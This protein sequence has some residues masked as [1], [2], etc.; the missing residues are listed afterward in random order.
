M[1]RL[2]PHTRLS[3][4]PEPVIDFVSARAARKRKAK[5][6]HAELSLLTLLQALLRLR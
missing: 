2:E 3:N 1:V 4:V 6:L 5:A